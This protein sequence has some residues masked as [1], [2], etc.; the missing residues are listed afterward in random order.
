[1]V[2]EKPLNYKHSDHRKISSFRKTLSILKSNLL[3]NLTW[4]RTV[5]IFFNY[6][7]CDDISINYDQLLEAAEYFK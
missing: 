7:T 1:M 3:G 4:P 6:R 2:D 5:S